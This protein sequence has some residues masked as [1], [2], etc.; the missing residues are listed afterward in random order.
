M[1]VRECYLTKNGNL[2]SSTESCNKGLVWVGEN[3][4]TMLTILIFMTL[5]KLPLGRN[6]WEL[7]SEWHDIEFKHNV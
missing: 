1:Y 3:I 4:P 6:I 2:Q 5:E 7:G